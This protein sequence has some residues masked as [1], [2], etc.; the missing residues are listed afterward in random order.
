M[1]RDK[2]IYTKDGTYK[3]RKNGRIKLIIDWNTD[4]AELIRCTPL[5]GSNAKTKK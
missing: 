2:Y 3:I 1:K 5:E 4:K